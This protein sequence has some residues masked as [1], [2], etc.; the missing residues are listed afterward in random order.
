KHT[1][2][3][4][5]NKAFP[6]TTNLADN[7]TPGSTDSSCAEATTGTTAYTLNDAG[8][9]TGDNAADTDA[10]HF[11][12]AGTYAVSEGTVPAGFAFENV[13]CMTTGGPTATTSGQSVSIG[14]LAGSTTECTFTNRGLPALSIL[15]TADHTAPVNAGDQIGFTVQLCNG[16]IVSGTCT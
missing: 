16:T 4:G 15:K 11:V 13:V 10:C 6:F 9:T 14:V 7:V 2:P 8:N 12:P 3:R 5:A 1:D